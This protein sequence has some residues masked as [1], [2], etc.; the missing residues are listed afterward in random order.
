MSRMDWVPCHEWG[1]RQTVPAIAQLDQPLMDPF[2][3][4]NPEVE[5]R[6]EESASRYFVHRI[7]GIVSFDWV[8][9]P[10]GGNVGLIQEVIWPG[11]IDNPSS[12]S[13]ISPGFVNTASGINA[14][15]WF[16]RVK[17]S[18]NTALFHD[19]DGDSNRWYSHID[20]TPKQVIDDGQIPL[21]SVYNDDGGGVALDYRLWVRMLL[22]PLG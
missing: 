1:V 21:Y 13:V 8:G 14:R 18:V 20:I 22:T 12:G 11:L 19:I 15:L 4:G 6:F 9:T 16:H 2:L 17:G 7:V 5:G 3:Y 10:S